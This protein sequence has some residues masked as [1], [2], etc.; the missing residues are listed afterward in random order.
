MCD[1]H[2]SKCCQ[3]Y[4]TYALDVS[5]LSDTA[6][7]PYLLPSIH[8]R[9]PSRMAELFDEYYLLVKGVFIISVVDE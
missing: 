6:I 7:L 5:R 8:E 3:Y 1:F 2:D 4:L 9:R